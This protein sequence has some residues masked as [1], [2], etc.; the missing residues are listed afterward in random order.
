MNHTKM[1]HFI[2]AAIVV[3]FLSSAAR[4]DSV[5]V[6]LTQDSQTAAAGSTVTFD[7]TV[8]NLSPTDTIYLNGDSSTTSS[9][10]LTIDDTPYSTNFPLSLDPNEV[11]GPFALFNIFIDPTTP[12][13]SYDINSFSILGGLNGNTFDTIGIADFSVTVASP[14]PTPE[15]R[16]FDLLLAGLLALS[17]IRQNRESSGECPADLRVYSP[18]RI[19]SN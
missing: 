18:P 10:L 14:V 13:G 17:F 11:S 3:L 6:T 19:P 2:L 7:A 4:A 1:V 5:D 15:P 9:L 16:P 12:D 8:T